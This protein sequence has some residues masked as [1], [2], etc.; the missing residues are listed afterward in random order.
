M[1][2]ERRDQFAFP[3]KYCPNVVTTSGRVAR[4]ASTDAATLFGEDG[5]DVAGHEEH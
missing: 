2:G 3:S 1:G 5:L 4:T